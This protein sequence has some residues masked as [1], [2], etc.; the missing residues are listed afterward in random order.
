MM[1]SLI[2]YNVRSRYSFEVNRN[3][4]NVRKPW[5]RKAY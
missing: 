1:S 4:E 2:S 5:G 3:I